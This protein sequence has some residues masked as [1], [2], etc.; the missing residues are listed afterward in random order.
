MKEGGREDPPST[1][2]T[3]AACTTTRISLKHCT[4]WSRPPRL[5]EAY[6]ILVPG[7]KHAPLASTK[8][9]GP[10]TLAGPCLVFRLMHDKGLAYQCTFL[11]EMGFLLLNA[12]PLMER[13]RYGLHVSC[14]IWR[15]LHLCHC[16]ADFNGTGRAVV[17]HPL[18]TDLGHVGVELGSTW[19]VCR[20]SD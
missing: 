2:P 7:W 4:C 10:Y 16:V 8:F 3:W 20:R 14:P 6:N 17:D 19:G 18:M 12:H 1:Q 9:A 13:C 5:R 11:E 15:H